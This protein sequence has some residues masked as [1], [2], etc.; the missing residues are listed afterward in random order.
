MDPLGIYI[1]MYIYIYVQWQVR[2]EAQVEKLQKMFANPTVF[3]PEG[4]F[5]RGKV[6]GF[7]MA[8]HFHG[9]MMVRTL[10]P[11]DFEDPNAV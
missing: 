2:A 11:R 4:D 7:S 8:I 3:V 10:K 1:Y 6:V 5:S 9:K